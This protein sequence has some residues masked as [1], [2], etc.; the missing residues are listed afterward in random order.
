MERDGL[1]SVKRGEHDFITG[2]PPGLQHA[3]GE[4]SRS[5]SQ[6]TV[7]TC[8]GSWLSNQQRRT[9]SDLQ[10]FN[11]QLRKT[12]SMMRPSSGG[13]N[14]DSRKHGWYH[15]QGQLEHARLADPSE[16][17]SW[18]WMARKARDHTGYGD[19]GIVSSGDTQCSAVSED[20]PHWFIG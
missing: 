8:A 5:H 17:G 19:N 18:A 6:P 4:I 7:L 15:P 11:N 1:R 12:S 9:R 2:T 13:T 14:Y 20:A 16:H 10:E 3:P